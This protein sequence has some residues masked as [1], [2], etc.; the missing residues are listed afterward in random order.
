MG[1][2]VPRLGGVFAG[3][4]I[5]PLRGILAAFRLCGLVCDG[6]DIQL[7]LVCLPQSRSIGRPDL[8]DS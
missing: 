7:P 3:Y 2:R 8:Q 1:E 4:Q 5:G 6:F